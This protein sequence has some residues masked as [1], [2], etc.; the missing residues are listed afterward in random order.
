MNNK[1]EVKIEMRNEYTPVEVEVKI[2]VCSLEDTIKRLEQDGF[3]L[4]VHA[5]KRTCIIT[6]H[7]MI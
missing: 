2:P 1:T 4:A 6:A 5:G 7:I 3:C